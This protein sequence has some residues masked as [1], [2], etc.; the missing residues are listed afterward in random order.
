[1]RP[2]V[3]LAE[4]LV[5]H[6]RLATSLREYQSQLQKFPA[7]AKT[8]LIDGRAPRV[9]ERL[10]QRDLA[11]TLRRIASDGANGFYRGRTAALIEAEMHRGGGIITR[12]DLA[13]YEAVWRDPITFQYRNQTV[14]SMPPPSSGGATIAEILNILEGY[15]LQRFGFLSADHIH[16]WT[17]AV[18]RAYADRNVYLA[19]PDF[20]AQPTT[21]MISDGYANQRRADIRMERDTPSADVHPGLGA[22][23][24]SQSAGAHREGE[25]TTH[26]SIVD[27]AGN[28]VSVTT[29]LN[30]LYGSLVTV[31]GAG[32]L[33]NNEMDDFATRPGAPN[34]F[35][36]V[37]GELNAIQPGKRMLSSMTP[38][39]LLGG[40]GRVRLVSGTPGGATIITT[41][42]QIIS[43]MVDF[44]MDL[45]NAT[46]APRLH[47][48]HLPDVLFLEHAGVPM[49]V[50]QALRSRGLT[51]QERAGYQG[52]TQSIEVLPNGMLV[53]VA[54]PRRGGTPAAVQ[55]SREVVQ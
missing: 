25:N 17:E 30:S 32:F 47:H 3:N 6:E 53:G 54:D 51:V 15:D 14:L 36:L 48:Q 20:A 42:A 50:Q 24:S 44:G 31:D 39:I 23:P 4:G 45:A 34:Q 40:D 33:L 28:A 49:A 7:T 22:I 55:D 37:Q 16:V 2:A 9:G 43:N 35:G 10:V 26:Y 46:G 27:A 52:D 29:T 1:M 41:M 18:K 19:D 12:V 8:F 38:I 11:E 5:V 21:R 13:R